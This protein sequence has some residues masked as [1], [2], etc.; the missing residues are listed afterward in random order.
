MGVADGAV[1]PE[2]ASKRNAVAPGLK[3]AT[4]AAPVAAEAATHEVAEATTVAVVPE[5]AAATEVAA[6]A[7]MATVA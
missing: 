2:V 4:D 3:A 1:R 6:A 7:E 5:T